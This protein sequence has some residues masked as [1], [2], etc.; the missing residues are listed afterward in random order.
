MIIW[1][2]RLTKNWTVPKFTNG[3]GSPKVYLKFRPG[4][5]RPK[6]SGRTFAHLHAPP[7][8]SWLMEKGEELN[9]VLRYAA[10]FFTIYTSRFPGTAPAPPTQNPKYPP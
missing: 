5:P 2:T 9:K 7:P 8:S 4:Q 1:R 10:L 3:R 6:L